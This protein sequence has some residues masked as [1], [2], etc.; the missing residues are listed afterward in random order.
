[1]F[2][3]LVFNPYKSTVYKTLTRYM[4]LIHS[5]IILCI[6]L[7]FITACKKHTF[8]PAVDQLPAET[9]TG[10]NTF[11]CLVNG[12]VFKPH[13]S[14]LTPFLGCFYQNLYGTDDPGYHFGLYAFDKS[15]VQ[16]FASVEVG[17]DSIEIKEN[18]II[19]LTKYLIP[20]YGDGQYGHY[21]AGQTGILY[22]TNDNLKGELNVKHFDSVNQIM[23]GTFWFNAVSNNGD[24]VKI[25]DGR[26]DMH[27]TR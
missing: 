9:Q 14:G 4:K 6:S 20:G 18:L 15:N 27:Y 13:G 10:A 2:V 21:K 3:Q 19:P 23:S 16:D 26:F 17:L 1:M 11:G 25:T 22:H 24:T 7:F 8:T 5:F 12:K